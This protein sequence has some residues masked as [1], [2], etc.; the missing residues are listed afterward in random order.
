MTLPEEMPAG[1]ARHPDHEQWLTELGRFTLT[2]ARLAFG[3][4]DILRV[5]A[6]PP[7]TSEQVEAL[8][9]KDTLGALCRKLDEYADTMPGNFAEFREVL[10]GARETRNDVMHATT[11]AWGLHRNRPDQDRHFTTIEDLA[12]ARSELEEAIRLADAVMAA[13]GGAAIQAWLAGEPRT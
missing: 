11:I 3:C 7:M 1:D 5:L 12:D 10:D 8:F 9:Q 13:D 2:A 4:C 6:T